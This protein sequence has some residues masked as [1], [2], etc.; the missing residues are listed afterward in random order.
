[1]SS[2]D[3]SRRPA[4]LPSSPESTASAA[5]AAREPEVALWVPPPP[6]QGQPADPVETLRAQPLFAELSTAQLRKVARLLHQRTY[7]PGEVVFREGD[8]GAGMYLITRGAVRIAMRLPD[9]VE[10]EL[11]LLQGGQFFGEMALLESAPRSASAVAVQRTE[12]LGFFQPDLESLV[13]RDSRLGS[14]ILWNL[15]RLMGSR[16]RA[17]SE[18]RRFAPK[19]GAR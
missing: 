17:V 14:L 7:Q 4:P 16:L 10:Q 2:A 15:A 1:M 18:A 9:G 11:A 8:P 5:S 13:D 12:L 19:D 6:P 3:A